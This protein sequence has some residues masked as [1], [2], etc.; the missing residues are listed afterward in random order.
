M[1]ISADHDVAKPARTFEFHEGID[2]AIGADLNSRSTHGLLN[3]RKLGHMGGWMDY[4][5]RF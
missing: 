3:I 1:A 5:G 2:H 4:N